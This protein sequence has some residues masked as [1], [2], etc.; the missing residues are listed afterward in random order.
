M[1][2]ETTKAVNSIYDEVLKERLLMLVEQ[3]VE[4]VM[5][6]EDEPTSMEADSTARLNDF[7]IYVG[8]HVEAEL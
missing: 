2:E 5:E 6:Q 1:S 4:D 7:Y 8:T 3:Y